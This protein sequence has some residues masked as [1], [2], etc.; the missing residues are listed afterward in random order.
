MEDERNDKRR[1][2]FEKHGA[3]KR[4]SMN[5]RMAGHDYCDRWMYLITINVAEGRQLLGRVRAADD[6]HA[7]PWV[8][9]SDLGRRVEEQWAAITIEQPII[10]SLAFCL[11]PDHV[12]GILFVTERLPRQLG[13]Y[14]ARFKAKTTAALRDC[15]AQ[16]TTLW[17]EGF[18]DRILAGDGQLE[19]WRN[20]LRDNPR[21]RWLRENRPE[22]F[23][24]L[25]GITVDGT[26]VTVMGN[27]F[28]LDYPD[29]VAVKCSRRLNEEQ[30][31]QDCERFMRL[32]AQGAVLVSPC[33]SPGEKAVMGRVFEAGYPQIV[34][35]ENGFAP[36]QKPYGRQFD[37]CASGRLLLVAPWEHHNERRPI[38][39]QQCRE[40]NRLAAAICANR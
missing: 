25:G 9:P 12:H 23:T 33:I 32:A 8:E 10:Q 29:K 2:W 37:A 5:R 18:N 19:R 20:Y 4:P 39:W 1:A 31:E 22:F 24:A 17:E 11:M 21:R 36:R 35:L 6:E 40:L 28:L 34:L 13:H 27:R 16:Y 14:I 30:I 15:V 7:W 3:K 26:A 38:T